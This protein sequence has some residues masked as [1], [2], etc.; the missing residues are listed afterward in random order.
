MLLKLISHITHIECAGEGDIR[1]GE[2][3]GVWRMA[4]RNPNK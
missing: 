1:V 2:G 4:V 3:L